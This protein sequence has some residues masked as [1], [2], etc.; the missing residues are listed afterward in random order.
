MT[1]S[2][3][4]KAPVRVADDTLRSF[5]GYYMKRAFNEVQADLSVRLKP[6]GL[7]M[8]TFSTLVLIVDNP[9]LRQSQLAEA[10]AIERPNIVMILDELQRKGL[11]TRDRAHDDRRAYAVRATDAGKQTLRQAMAVMRDHEHQVFDVLTQTERQAL[12]SA[13]HKVETGPQGGPT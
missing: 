2:A 4:T 8:V 6:L 5:A 9:G 1:G 7:R 3:P 12:I 10:L 13:L 11:I